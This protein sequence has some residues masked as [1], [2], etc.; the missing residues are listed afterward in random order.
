MR[1][2]K[3]HSLVREENLKVLNYAAPI[4]RSHPKKPLAYGATTLAFAFLQIPWK[5]VI[6]YWSITPNGLDTYKLS[7]LGFALFL[8]IWFGPMII[9]FVFGLL[10]VK[11]GGIGR[12]NLIAT[13]GLAILSIEF[14]YFILACIF[15]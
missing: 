1:R 2:R 11:Y 14:I 3:D 13:I 8:I 5:Y 4:T 9:G 6:I 15:G 12:R 7:T 10:S